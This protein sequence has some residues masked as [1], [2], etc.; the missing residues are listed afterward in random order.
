MVLSIMQ[1]WQSYELESMCYT[2]SGPGVFAELRRPGVVAEPS[3]SIQILF[4]PWQISCYRNIND[5]GTFIG[6]RWVLGVAPWTDCA[7][8]MNS[9]EDQEQFCSSAKTSVPIK[10]GRSSCASCVRSQD[11]KRSA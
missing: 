5:E 7:R 11:K 1:N 9:S 4:K 3:G 10:H 6:P 2:Q 8:G